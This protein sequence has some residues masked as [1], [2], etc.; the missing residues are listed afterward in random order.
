MVAPALD[1]N[2]G[3]WISE[4]GASLVYIEL[5]YSRDCIMRPCFKPTT[6]RKALPEAGEMAQ[7]HFTS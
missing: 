7:P 3:R 1:S 6:K 4:L 2:R 5:Q